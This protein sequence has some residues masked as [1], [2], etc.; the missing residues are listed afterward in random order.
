MQNSAQKAIVS[1]THTS[2]SVLTTQRPCTALQASRGIGS[3]SQLPEQH[4][5][6]GTLVYVGTI[7]GQVKLVKMFSLSTSIIGVCLQPVLYSKA[8]ASSLPLALKFVLGGFF[9]FFIFLT[10]VLLHFLSKRYMTSLYY[11]GSTGKFTATNYNFFV[12]EV[13]TTF[14]REQVSTANTGMLT[15]MTVDKKP[16]FFDPEMFLDHEIYVRM[17]RYDEPLDISFKPGQYAGQPLRDDTKN[18]NS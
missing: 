12:R 17:M 16:F 4:P 18:E 7:S 5:E 13:Q 8:A 11:N 1:S 15:T 3:T 14:T 2:R 10:P 6:K 9:N